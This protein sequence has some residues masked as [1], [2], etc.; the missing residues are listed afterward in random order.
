MAPQVPGVVAQVTEPPSAGPWFQLHVEVFHGTMRFQHGLENHIRG[1]RDQHF[2]GDIQ[3][4]DG[5][6]ILFSDHAFSPLYETVGWMRYDAAR[7]DAWLSVRR[8]V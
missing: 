2:F 6:F 5:G 3:S 4:L 8:L 7:Q 1:G